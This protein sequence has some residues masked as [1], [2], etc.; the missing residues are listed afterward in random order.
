MTPGD[1]RQD[2]AGQ[3]DHLDDSIENVLK[4]QDKDDISPD[5][6][7]LIF[8]GK[9]LEYGHADLRQDF[10]GQ[11]ESEQQSCQV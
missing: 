7:P 8:T 2:L 1:L 9:Q 6:Q 4:I 5:Q 10:D 3:D 11:G